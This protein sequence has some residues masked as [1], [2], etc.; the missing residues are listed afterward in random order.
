LLLLCCC[1]IVTT[2]VTD[3]SSITV[4]IDPP[5]LVTVLVPDRYHLQLTLP[6]PI[7]RDAEIVR[8]RPRM[9]RLGMLCTVISTTEEAEPEAAP[10]A[11][12]HEQLQEEPRSAAAAQVQQECA[13]AARSGAGR[14]QQQQRADQAAA[15]KPARQVKALGHPGKAVVPEN[16]CDEQAREMMLLTVDVSGSLC[17]LSVPSIHGCAKWHDT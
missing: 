5:H 9:G 7:S 6:V 4:E 10:A 14:R 3:D 15:A 8:F 2:G 11:A 13:D 16:R 1:G 17:L 12:E